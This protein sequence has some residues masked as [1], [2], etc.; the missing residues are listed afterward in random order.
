MKISDLDRDIEVCMHQKDEMR[1]QGI[2]RERLFSR[3]ADTHPLF[4]LR[5]D[6]AVMVRRSRELVRNLQSADHRNQ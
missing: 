1:C 4:S 5:Q 3:A 6:T 2:G